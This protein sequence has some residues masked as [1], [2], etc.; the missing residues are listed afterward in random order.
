M[1]H[2][3]QGLNEQVAR[4]AKGGFWPDRGQALVG[5]SYILFEEGAVMRSNLWTA[6]NVKVRRFLLLSFLPRLS[7][8]LGFLVTTTLHNE[9]RTDEKKAGVGF[10]TNG[11]SS[12][13][14]GPPS[15]PFQSP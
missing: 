3:D 12:T 2:A 5:G 4:H 6:G 10:P 8:H 7:L 9:W 1:C 15:S 14:V 13:F 11:R